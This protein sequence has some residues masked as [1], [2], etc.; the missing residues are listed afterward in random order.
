MFILHKNQLEILPDFPFVV[1]PDI[2]E[3]GVN[4]EVIRNEKDWEN[5]P[6]EN[7]LI[8][9]EFID[10]PLEYGVFYAK[11]PGEKNG[12]ILSITGKEFLRF[13]SDGKITLRDFINNNIRAYFRKEYLYKKFESQLDEIHPKGTQILLEPVGNHN[14]GTLFFDASDSISDELNQ[15]VNTIANLIE[16]FY[17]GRF[18]VKSQSLEDFQKGK[19]IVLEI[20]GSNSEATHIYD[21][22]FNLLKAYREVK[23]HLD[24]QYQIA[25]QNPKCFSDR[26]FFKAVWKRI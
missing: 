13:E 11:F 18:D 25:K 1:K 12:K 3:R 8:I 17:Y 2:G 15:V 21:P 6:I 26:E 14:R 16:G 23:R 5:Y 22:K 7:N 10:F 24:V 4:V 19:F 9:Q 20:N